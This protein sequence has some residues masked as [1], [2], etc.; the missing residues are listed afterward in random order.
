MRKIK[1]LFRYKGVISLLLVVIIIGLTIGYSTYVKELYIEG[2]NVTYRKKADIRVTGASLYNNSEDVVN[3]YLEYNVKNLSSDVTLPYEESY[4]TYNIEITNFG[5]VEMGILNITGL[6]DNL[7]YELIDYNLKSKICDSSNNCKLGIGKTFQIKIKYKDNCYDSDN[8]NY[9]LKLDFDFRSFHTITYNDID[10]DYPSTIIDGDTLDITLS[11]D[12]EG[13]LI[14]GDSKTL[15]K[16]SDYTYNNNKLVIENVSSDLTIIKK[17]ETNKL[18]DIMLMNE[19]NSYTVDNAKSYIDSKGTPDFSKNATTDEGIYKTN[20]EDGDVYYFRGD[21][22]DN[23]VIFAKF[24]WRIVRSTGDGG[25]KLIYDGSPVNGVCNN[26]GSNTQI[27]ASQFNSSYKSLAYVGY[28]YGQAYTVYEQDLSS[29][30]GTIVYGND[31]TFDTTTGEYTLV[32][33][34]ESDVSNWESD[35]TTIGSKYHYTCW[36]DQS[37]CSTV[38]YMNAIYKSNLKPYYFNLTDGK[39][40]TDI[41]K[42]MLEDSTNENDSVAKSNIDSWYKSNLIDYTNKLEDTVWCNDRTISNYGGWNKDESNVNSWLYFS[43]Y[44]RLNS[45]K[46]SLLCNRLNDKFTVNLGTGNGDLKYPVGLIT[47]DEIG[48]A[49]GVI[50]STNDSYYLYTGQY[51]WSGSPSIFNYWNALEFLLNSSGVFGYLDVTYSFGL[52]PMVSLNPGTEIIQ[53]DGSS[54]NPYLVD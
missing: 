28:M 31:V 5:N 10:G 19:N 9:H 17:D 51:Y 20:D 22:D 42:E 48:Y 1:Y 25:V 15:V 36:S 49:G 47:G 12:I 29:L 18:L 43:T 41:L 23:H 46:P 39:T 32:D 35:Y 21:V 2:I 50:W 34:I 54:D 53:G 44:G 52:R 38:S 3:N 26:T 13:L 7:D 14:K 37:K 16:D 8:L 4:I 33:T 30:S 27:M 6:D 40:H 11:N 24:C 45:K